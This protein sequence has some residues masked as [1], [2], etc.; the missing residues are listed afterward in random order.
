MQTEDL[1]FLMGFQAENFDFEKKMSILL[2][3][4]FWRSTFKSEAKRYTK[5]SANT[6]CEL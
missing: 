5:K 2:T 6:F 4:E 3:L 1:F